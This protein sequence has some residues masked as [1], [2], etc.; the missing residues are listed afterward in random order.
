LL[1]ED[2]DPFEEIKW[3]QVD[4]DKPLRKVAVAAVVQTRIP[5]N[6]MT[7]ERRGSVEWN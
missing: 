4:S 3:N 7:T 5:G 1:S 6:I 2:Y